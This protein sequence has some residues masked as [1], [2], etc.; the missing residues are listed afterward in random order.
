L[1][2]QN[3]NGALVAYLALSNHYVEKAYQGFRR[4]VSKRAIK[5]FD[6][7]MAAMAHKNNFGEYRSA[8]KQ[9]PPGQFIPCYGTPT[10]AMDCLG[11]GADGI[12]SCAEVHL[13]DLL[14]FTEGNRDFID[15]SK[16]VLNL[17]KM[18][19][20][21]KIISVFRP[22]V[23]KFAVVGLL[24]CPPIVDLPFVAVHLLSQWTWPCR[25]HYQ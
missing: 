11:V 20:M 19:G 10:V 4:D 5:E 15:E 7:L 24:C 25:R 17:A 1:E 14:Y 22:A 6:E 2:L 23:A 12:M 8:I 3:F 18:D 9:I 21:G 13:K 16:T